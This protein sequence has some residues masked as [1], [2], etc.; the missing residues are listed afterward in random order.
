MKKFFKNCAALLAFSALTLGS[1]ATANA[2][3]VDVDFG[4]EYNVP[5]GQAFEG[6]FILLEPSTV[7]VEITETSGDLYKGST[8]IDTNNIQW[9]NPATYIFDNLSA[10]TYTYKV[11]AGFNFT[12]CT[13][14][15]ILGTG[16]DTGGGGDTGGGNIDDTGEHFQLPVNGDVTI[17]LTWGNRDRWYYTPTQDG[18]LT[19]EITNG[20]VPMANYLFT[21]NGTPVSVASSVK[22]PYDPVYTSLSWE[23]TARTTYFFTNAPDED[24]K[25]CKF[26]FGDGEGGNNGDGDDDEPFV[27][28][29]GY[30][31]MVM[32][33]VYNLNGV[34]STK[35]YFVPS[36]SGVLVVTQTGSHDTHL[37]IE[38]P[39]YTQEY[40]YDNNY[41]IMAQT[42]DGGYTGENPYTLKY[43]VAAGVPYYFVGKLMT[44]D[45]LSSVEFNF[46]PA[47]GDNV[48]EE[49]L[50]YKLTYTD[51]VYTYTPS[52]TGVL[53]VQWSNPNVGGSACYETDIVWGANQYFLYEDYG[54]SRQVPML[55]QGDGQGGW[56][57]TFAV[58]K[59]E[60]Y[61]F[62]SP[63]AKPFQVVFTLEEGVVKPT[64]KTIN[65]TPGSAWSTA[66]YGYYMNVLT[67]PTNTSIEKATLTYVP[68]GATEQT[69]I[70]FKGTPELA[71]DLQIPVDELVALIN[72]DGIAA[73]TDYI[74][75]LWGLKAG[76]NYVTE[77]GLLLGDKYVTIGGNGKVEIT[78]KNG[79]AP[80]MLS[81][82]FPSP[83][84]K[85]WE[86]NDPDGIATMT[87]DSN[88]VKVGEVSVMGG[89][90]Y[91]GSSPSSEDA[92]KSVIIPEQN[93][94]CVNNV[95]TIDFTNMTFDMGSVSEV[96]VMVQGIQ[97]ENSLYAKFDGIPVYQY[98]TSYVADGADLGDKLISSIIPAPESNV[99]GFSEGELLE[100][101]L[102]EYVMEQNPTAVKAVILDSDNNQITA[103]DFEYRLN[104]GTYIYEFPE[105]IVFEN[106]KEYQFVVSVYGAND[107][108]IGKETIYW[109]GVSGSGVD[110]VG[111]ENGETVI[112]TLDGVR[113][114]AD[115]VKGLSN[116][117]YIVNGKKVLVRK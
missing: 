42:Q 89:H 78:Y 70:D 18:M 113:V 73:D 35:L 90:Q 71:G 87:F 95:V 31:Q 27:A 76:G 41:G 43:G 103:M 5:K 64:V 61:Y 108:L 17:T 109:I 107:S 63:N 91:Y 1:Y 79:T 2:L 45:D 16:D 69:T 13:V 39:Q 8:V 60:T 86:R 21:E 54:L 36:T 72:N 26:T 77:N 40:G 34:G 10:G 20:G 55:S 24:G 83:W 82:D 38:E 12:G 44:G 80:V 7:S 67:S 74:I 102:Y 94:K 53:S 28:P 19:M 9:G 4:T 84:K 85:S 92:E 6:S 68:T 111:V 114:K 66:D 116:G 101:R 15:I 3:T 49:N 22:D 52:A 98:Y 48:I 50:P 46:E 104:T 62:H 106:G 33:Q 37:F 100:M 14:K 97:G 110:A 105:D 56:L 93:I 51:P 117:I 58:Y 30:S 99:P 65:P 88:I 115:S 81:S 29:E 112:F 47:S 32:E 75:T 25:V 59:G 57:V 23:L 11:D 96:T